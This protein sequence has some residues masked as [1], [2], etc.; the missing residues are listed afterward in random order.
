MPFILVVIFVGA[1]FGVINI[2][3]WAITARNVD[4]IPNIELVEF[5]EI[6]YL[7]CEEVGGDAYYRFWVPRDENSRYYSN[8]DKPSR[9]SV[10]VPRQK[11]V[12]GW[13]DVADGT[14]FHAVYHLFTYASSYLVVARFG[15]LSVREFSD[16]KAYRNK[17]HSLVVMFF[18]I[19][20]VVWVYFLERRRKTDSY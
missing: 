1:I 20:P 16:A 5:P 9:Q 4:E 7:V 11:C 15:D 19:S 12:E 3:P 6:Y 10:S 18:I 17:I 14:S 13:G 2:F 8:R